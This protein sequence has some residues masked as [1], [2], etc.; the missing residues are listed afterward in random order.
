MQIFHQ[1]HALLHILLHS[2]SVIQFPPHFMIIDVFVYHVHG[3]WLMCTLHRLLP[4]HLSITQFYFVIPHLYVEC[5]WSVCGV[6]VEC[7]WSI[8]GVYVEC[9][10]LYANFNPFPFPYLILQYSFPLCS[11]FECNI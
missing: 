2:L 5:M 1:I 10:M 8:C 9:C 3:L 6:Y 7:M 4:S 11:I